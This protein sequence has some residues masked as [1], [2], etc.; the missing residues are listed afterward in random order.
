MAAPLDVDQQGPQVRVPP[1]FDTSL[2]PKLRVVWRQLAG[3][4]PHVKTLCP[5]NAQL[6]ARTPPHVV[7]PVH[8]LWYEPDGSGGHGIVV[9]LVLVVLLVVVDV[10]VVVTQSAVTV[11]STSAVTTA[12]TQLAST[13][14]A[15]AF[16]WPSPPQPVTLAKA[17][18]NLP[19]A[20]VRHAANV[21]GFFV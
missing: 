7:Q 19:F 15:M 12:S 6:H 13:V 4:N 9:E 2:H 8:V 10:V 1:Q 16:S 14:D 18:R 3:T 21:A 5:G 11:P 17:D 20:F